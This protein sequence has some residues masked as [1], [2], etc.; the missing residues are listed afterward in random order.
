ME[1]ITAKFSSKCAKT[2]RTIKKGDPIAYDRAG[3]KAYCQHSHSYSAGAPI[4]G[5]VDSL[6]DYVQA[7]EDAYFDNFCQQNGI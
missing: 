5:E 1:F 6:A 4:R 3:K 2:G 7:Q